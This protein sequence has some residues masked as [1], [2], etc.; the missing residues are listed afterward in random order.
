[1][2]VKKSTKDYQK[3]LVETAPEVSELFSYGTG[4]KSRSIKYKQEHKLAVMSTISGSE[5]LLLLPGSGSE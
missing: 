3:C 2:S 4:K 1:M 5:S